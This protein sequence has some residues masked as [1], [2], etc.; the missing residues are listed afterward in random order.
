LYHRDV[1]PSRIHIFKGKIIKY[2]SIGLPYSFK[3]LLKRENFSGHVNYSAPELIL[4]QNHFSGKVDI[5]SLGCCAYYIM[6]KKDPFNGRYPNETK[7]NILH[8]MFDKYTYVSQF[9][10]EKI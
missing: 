9:I 8:G 5:W 1:H 3:K 4:E 2:N 7:Y 10:R 6:T